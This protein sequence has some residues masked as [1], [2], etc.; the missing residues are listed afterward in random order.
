MELKEYFRLGWRWAWLLVLGM[1]LAL[2][3]AYILTRY[4]TPIY[5]AGTK[6]L[7]MRAPQVSN[8]DLGYLSDQQL[9]QTYIQ[10]LSTRPVLEQVSKTLGYPVNKEQLQVQQVRDTPMISLSVEDANPERAA[11]IANTLVT[12]LISQNES[13]QSSRYSSSENSLQAQVN[14]VETQ[15][16]T[17]QGQIDDLAT[18]G[19]QLQTSQV[20]A[21]ITKLKS[22]I[23]QTE[24]TI[25]GMSGSTGSN[26]ALTD[27]QAQLSQSKSMLALYQEIYTNLVVAGKPSE[28]G[29]VDRLSRLQKTLD[30]YQQIYL[31]LLKSMEDIRLARLQNSSNVVQIESA[32][33][34]VLPVRPN[35]L[36]NLGLSA[37]VGLM[38][39]AGVVFTIEYMNDTLKSPVDVNNLLG[40]PIIGYVAELK[41]TPEQGEIYVSSNPRSPVAEAFR[42]LRANLEFADKEKPVK[43]ILVTSTRPGEGKT[44]VATNLAAIFAQ[45]GKKVILVDADLRRPNVH[46]MTGVQNRMGLSTLFKAQLTVDQVWRKRPGNENLYVITSGSPLENPAELLSSEKMMLIMADLR[47]AADI[48]V[49]DSPPSVVVDAQILS[50]LV[51]GVIL[52]V[53][54]GKLPIDEAQ[55]TLTQMNTAGARMLGV[56]FNRIPTNRGHYYGGYRYYNH[57]GYQDYT[58]DNPKNRSANITNEPPQVMEA[59]P[60][61]SAT[62]PERSNGRSKPIVEPMK[63]K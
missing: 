12:V 48:V 35:L 32:Q 51:D 57:Q 14:Q 40:L 22:D 53:Q 19:V 46:G 43:T 45:S 9:V 55:A 41:K 30:L 28:A 23:A 36:I 58:R 39:A 5:Q 25:Q 31:Q 3:G 27:M 29:T 44:T 47:K 60:A 38:L 33:A 17:L 24:A 63:N 49:I 10:M 61:P 50:S 4:Q 16:N 8:S 6:I 56:V 26:S 1:I 13:L 59:S 54:P 34:P 52:V 21:E 11:D 62:V 18:Q 7:V 42:S 2:V 20:E 37:V 15:I